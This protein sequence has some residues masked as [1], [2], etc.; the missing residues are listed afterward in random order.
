MGPGQQCVVPTVGPSAAGPPGLL[1]A[2][3]FDYSTG[4]FPGLRGVSTSTRPARAR[5]RRDRS[6]AGPHRLVQGAGSVRGDGL[7]TGMGVIWSRAVSN[8]SRPSRHARDR[9]GRALPASDDPASRCMRAVRG[10]RLRAAATSPR[11]AL[12]RGPPTPA[13][14]RPPRG[15]AL[16]R[17]TVAAD[18]DASRTGRTDQLPRSRTGRDRRAVDRTATAQPTR[19]RQDQRGRPAAMVQ[20]ATPNRRAHSPTTSCPPPSTPCS[21]RCAPQ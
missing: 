4:P 10:C 9:R 3:L 19:R 13:P 1:R 2:G 20:P 18:R 6:V 15:P 14:S 5:R 11:R 21:S 12:L 7:S 16:R 8:T 17:A